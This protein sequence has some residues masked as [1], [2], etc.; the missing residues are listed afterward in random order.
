MM[1]RPAGVPVP[2][3]ARPCDGSVHHAHATELVAITYGASAR[4]MTSVGFARPT[5]QL[6]G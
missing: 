1:T 6:F 4:S 2:R 5:D 3:A